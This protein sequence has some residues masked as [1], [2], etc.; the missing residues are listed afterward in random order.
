MAGAGAGAASGASSGAAGGVWGAG[1]GAVVGAVGG[2]IQEAQSRAEASRLRRRTRKG[3]EQGRA[4]T[5]KETY[6][7][8]N[9]KEYKIANQFALNTYGYEGTNNAASLGNAVSIGGQDYFAAPTGTPFAAQDRTNQLAGQFAE[10]ISARNQLQSGVGP[11]GNP[12][13]A[14]QIAALEAKG[15]NDRI[16]QL[17]SHAG[18]LDSNQKNAFARVLGTQGVDMG[19]FQELRGDY[20]GRNGQPQGD[21]LDGGTGADLGVIETPLT[22]HFR[23]QIGVAQNSRGIYSSQASAAAEASG[24]A[25]YQYEQQQ[26]MLPTLERQAR[27]GSDTYHAYE[28]ANL[29]RE[30]QNTT[31]GVGVYGAANPFTATPGGAVQGGIAGGMAGAS[32]GV[33]IATL[34]VQQDYNAERLKLAANYQKTNSQN[35][36]GTQYGGMNQY[37]D[38]HGIFSDFM[39]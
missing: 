37:S 15:G 19:Q 35:P 24:L 7:I 23:T 20:L 36:Y 6:E 3:I 33:N 39:R 38:P 17:M 14:Q 28:G 30:V 4:I 26:Q 29:T 25:A 13:S 34:G 2:A 32:L 11:N 21:P 16:D 31:G 1:I 18:S 10:V 12:L 22:N 8:L 5:A 9:S 27:F